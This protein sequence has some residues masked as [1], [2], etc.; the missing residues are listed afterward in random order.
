MIFLLLLSLVGLSH[1]FK[2]I[3][4]IS[5]FISINAVLVEVSICLIFDWYDK[6]NWYGQSFFLDINFSPKEEC[7]AHNSLENWPL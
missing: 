2:E 7:G 6:F 5:E 1:N 3:V 4:H